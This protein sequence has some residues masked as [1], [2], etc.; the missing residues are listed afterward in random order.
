MI[1]TCKTSRSKL[2]M[3]VWQRWWII[4]NYRNVKNRNAAAPI[5]RC[6]AGGLYVIYGQFTQMHVNASVCIY[7]AKCMI[8]CVVSSLVLYH[9]YT[10]I[11][12]CMYS[13]TV[14][15]HIVFNGFVGALALRNNGIHQSAF[16]IGRC[17]LR[18]N[19]L[20]L[21]ETAQSSSSLRSNCYIDS[22]RASPQSS[23][24]KVL[25]RNTNRC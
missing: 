12:L 24:R 10:L 15:L 2:N 5:D 7:V 17:R 11:A 23:K 1:E 14:C 8:V 18:Q 19:R 22:V 13:Y 9:W 16:G 3:L 25:K 4:E 20:L 21:C 6:P